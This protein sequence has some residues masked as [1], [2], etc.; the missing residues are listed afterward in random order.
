MARASKWTTEHVRTAQKRAR[1]LRSARRLDWKQDLVAQ[2]RLARERMVSELLHDEAELACTTWLAYRYL[3]AFERTELFTREYE[4]I[5]RRLHGQYVDVTAADGMRPIH[6][7]FV[8]NDAA[9]MTSL[10]KARQ[11][12]DL[13]GVPY[14]IFLRVSMN[15]AVEHRRYKHVPRPNQLCQQ[16]QI[17]AVEGAWE[18]EKQTVQLFADDWDPRFFAPNGC[19]D[20][21]RSAAL[22]ALVE[23]VTHGSS[24]D[25]RS[26][27][28]WMFMRL[29]LTEAEARAR[30][31]PG[32]VD[33]A[34]KIGGSP[35]VSLADATQLPYMPSC[36]GLI[37]PGSS[38]Y[39]DGCRF[40]AM[41]ERF[42]RAVD[43]RLS[44][45]HGTVDPLIA[46]ERKLA[47]D[48][49]RKSRNRLREAKRL[50]S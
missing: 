48:R 36:I 38:P 3:T 26:L 24:V 19:S 8:Q 32:V 10:W 9:E 1:I 16:W 39:C 5:Y 17:E 23:R 29:A 47:R 33:E 37:E 40:A 21:V 41:C 50:A 18:A 46:R 4:V 45:A 2:L 13:L 44:E 30:F 49:K 27:A 15:A 7:E 14:P 35:S 20:R 6:P 22:D 43:K 28:S 34:V 25:A 31:N 42:R 12:A 11:A